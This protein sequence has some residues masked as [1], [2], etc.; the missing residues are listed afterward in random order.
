MQVDFGVPSL[1]DYVATLTW[2]ISGALVGIR[3]N[4][5]FTGV[6]VVALLS[7]TGGGL[8]R[9]AVLLQRTPVFL[10]DPVYLPLIAA[11]T[12]LVT[13]FTAAWTSLR[14]GTS[15]RK[16]VDIVDALGTPAF[17]LVG[18]QLAEERSIPTAGTIFTG[19]VNG[20]AGGLL[21]DVVVRD[22]PALLRP[23]QFV[24]LTLTAACGLFIVLRQYSIS[25]AEAALAT[26]CAFF[27][28][29]VLAVRFN[30]RSRAISG[31][32][33]PSELEENHGAYDE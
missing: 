20:V 8:V 32:L 31:D 18:M 23:G 14:Q 26:V 12:V 29:R 21:R 3:K 9:D 33:S 22:V 6:F 15:V 25:P 4:F 13:V 1:F 19:V 11:T 24:T 17:A 7:S 10:L 2:A 5:D 28:A 16:L 27:T 30:W